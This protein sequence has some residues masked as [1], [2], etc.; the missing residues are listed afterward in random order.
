[1]FRIK[2]DASE[3]LTECSLG[4]T[5]TLGDN[6]YFINKDMHLIGIIIDGRLW[7]IEN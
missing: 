7:F 2:F 4:S 1:M 6:F 3:F 5:F